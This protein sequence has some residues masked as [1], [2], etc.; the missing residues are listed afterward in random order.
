MKEID[1]TVV[2]AGMV[3]RIA[4]DDMKG[5]AIHIR[6][7]LK[8]NRVTME[9]SIEEAGAILALLIA[10]DEQPYSSVLYPIAERVCA[11]LPLDLRPIP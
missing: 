8:G 4:F 9:C 3:V 11:K 7:M 2:A 10:G 1:C 5:A 6:E